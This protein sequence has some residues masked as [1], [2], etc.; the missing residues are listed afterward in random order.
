M[1]CVVNCLSVTLQ[2]KHVAFY[3]VFGFYLSIAT[4]S[5]EDC[6]EMLGTCLVLP[7]LVTR[8]SHFMD[9]F[10]TEEGPLP[11]SCLCG[12]YRD[13]ARERCL[14]GP[15]SEVRFGSKWGNWLCKVVICTRRWQKP[16]CRIYQ[17]VNDGELLFWGRNVVFGICSQRWGCV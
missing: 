9:T 6:V 16:N 15:A 13:S 12:K 3:F 4:S 17:L 2:E 8:S 5:W 10:W 1:Y 14:L 7:C 11:H